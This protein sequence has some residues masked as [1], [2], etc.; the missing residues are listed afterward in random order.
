VSNGFFDSGVTV[1]GFVFN[2]CSVSHYHNIG[3]PGKRKR[4]K[5]GW[6]LTPFASVIQVKEWKQ[7]HAD[8]TVT[9]IQCTQCSAT[10]PRDFFIAYLRLHGSRECQEYIAGRI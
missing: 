1:D 3:V 7:G 6:A 5:D 4:D 2:N 9:L 8:E 10:I